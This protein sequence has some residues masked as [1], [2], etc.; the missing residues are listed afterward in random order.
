MSYGLITEEIFFA[1]ALVQA[2]GAFYVLLA[3]VEVIAPVVEAMNAS[4]VAGGLQVLSPRF[5]RFF[6]ASVVLVAGDMIQP[7]W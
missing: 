4:S 5:L 3:T 7:S 2:G 6:F 1:L